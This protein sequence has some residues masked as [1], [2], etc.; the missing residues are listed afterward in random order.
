MS[1]FVKQLREAT[2]QSG[3]GQAFFRWYD[4]TG[5]KVEPE[6]IEVYLSAFLAGCKY[7]RGQINEAMAKES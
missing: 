6:D 2:S 4:T 7:N 3:S 1:I 5:E